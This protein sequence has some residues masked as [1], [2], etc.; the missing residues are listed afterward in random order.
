M[1]HA[2]FGWLHIAGSTMVLML[3]L[4]LSAQAIEWSQEVDA[5]EGTIVVYQPQPESLE[6]NILTGRSAMSLE[7]K[8]GKDPIFGACWFTARIDSQGDDD[9]V[10]VRDVE[11]TKVSWP[12]SKDAG[13]QRLTRI[14]EDAIPSAGFDISRE[15]LAASLST[16]EIQQRSL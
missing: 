8:N 14:V 12:D 7:L 13:E 11:V 2:W 6:G 9:T 4:P 16:A 5:R 1:T 10:L 15:R 3:G